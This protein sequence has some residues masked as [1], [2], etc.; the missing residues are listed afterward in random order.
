MAPKQAGALEEA[1]VVVQAQNVGERGR[2]REQAPEEVEVLL[3]LRREG[4]RE[5]HEPDRHV[6]VLRAGR[7]ALIDDQHRA[8]V[9]LV[10]ALQ[11][12]HDD[13]AVRHCT[14]LLQ[15]AGEHSTALAANSTA[16]APMLLQLSLQTLTDAQQ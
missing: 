13:T 3:A 16:L 12:H 1:V 8:A 14:L 5:I 10:V 2:Q 9:E 6:G 4:V 15:R 11:L 7:V